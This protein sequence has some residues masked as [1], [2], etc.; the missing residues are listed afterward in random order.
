MD[1]YDVEMLKNRSGKT[2]PS[3]LKLQLFAIVGFILRCQDNKF[4]LYK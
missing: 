4:N 3:P 2:L 1:D